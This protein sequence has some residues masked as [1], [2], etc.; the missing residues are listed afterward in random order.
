VHGPFPMRDTP[1]SSG[2]NRPI[3]GLVD[4]ASFDRHRSARRHPECPER[5]GA[6]RTGFAS[7]ASGARVVSVAARDIRSDEVSLVH[8]AGHLAALE[9][10]IPRDRF[11]DLDADTFAGPGT[12]EAMLRAAGGAAELGAAIARGD[13]TRGFALLRPPGH[14]AERDRAMGFCLLNNVA[15]AAR[16]AQA[17]GAKRVAIV[18]WDVHHGNG[19]QDVFESDPDVLFVSL[20]QWPLYPG[21]GAPGE[22]GRGAGAGSTANLAL[23]PGS[24]PAEYAHAF[25][26][27]VLPL[28]RGFAPDVILVSA[29]YDAHSNDPLASM[30]LDD[31]SYQAMATSLIG[32]ADAL[33]HGKVGFVLEGGYDLAALESSVAATTRAALGDERELSHEKAA[34]ASVAAV[35]HTVR[36]LAPHWPALLSA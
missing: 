23:P 35:D 21:T 10:S 14:H 32:V 13:V 3:I 22:I 27:V 11:V 33:G 15:L 16:A 4:D 29:G 24:G 25:R 30:R 31:A 2:A 19:T 7:G 34:A 18:D 36:A 26:R 17:A 12:L 9:A 1:E 5:L 6:A 20:H 28:V 8:R